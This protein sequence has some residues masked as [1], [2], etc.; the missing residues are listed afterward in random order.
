MGNVQHNT[1]I[2]LITCSKFT[3]RSVD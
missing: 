3:F 2:I 1:G